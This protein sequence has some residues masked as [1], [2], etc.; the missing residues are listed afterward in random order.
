MK[1]KITPLP[2]VIIG[3][4][5]II[6]IFVAAFPLSKELQFVPE[7][8]VDVSDS[9]IKKSDEIPLPFKSAQTFGYFTKS[10]AILNSATFPV[11][12]S[13]SDFFY[14]P[15][16]LSDDSIS[17]YYPDGN[18]ACKL[19]ASGFP[20]IDEN[21]IFVFAPGGSSFSQFSTNGFGH[22]AENPLCF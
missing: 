10:G 13:I 19:E 21:R 15:F 4:F 14:A 6:Y 7:W 2:F 3:V 17:V 1:F 20:F 12:L 16:G 9:E 18:S 22:I 8:T 11:K 5:T